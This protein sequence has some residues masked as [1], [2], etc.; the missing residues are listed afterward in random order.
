HIDYSGGHVFP[1]AITFGTYAVVK[2]RED[3]KIRLYSNNFSELGVYEFDLDKL[4]YDEKDD[5]T[6]KVKGVLSIMQ[7]DDH[8]LMHGFDVVYEGNIPNGAGLSSSASIEVL[9][10]VIADSINELDLKKMTLVKIALR[11]ENDFVGVQCGIMDQFAVTMGKEDTAML[12]DTRTNE[13]D[14]A[15]LDLKDNVIVI[16]NTN[17]QRGLS[18]SA[19]NERREQCDEALAI[20]NTVEEK[21]F[22][23]EHNLKTLNKNKDLFEDDL[24]FK[25]ARHAISE[26]LRTIKA[27]EVLKEDDL[28]TFGQ[29]MDESHAS[30]RDDYDVT[31]K[32]LDAIVWAAQ[33][34]EGVHGA[35][36]TGAGFGGCAL[37]I[38][39]EKQ[40][41]SFIEAVGKEY[42]KTIGYAAD[43]YIATA[44]KGAGEI[45]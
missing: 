32:E 33:K 37:A 29:L 14:Y 17:K 27:A 9:S 21:D 42:E 16:M 38:V 39:K 45:K 12:L 36:V 10:A 40:V 44:G 6:N 22:L 2:K 11:A 26:N 25:R 35:R 7:E 13:F 28:E 23:C 31:G 3:R 18:D 34:Q 1:C 30:L 4:V 15:P 43:F 8:E 24:V 5:W 20:L 19:Y 41:D